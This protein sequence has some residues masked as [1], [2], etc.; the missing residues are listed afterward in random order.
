MCRHVS[1]AACFGAAVGNNGPMRLAFVLRSAVLVAVA[2]LVLVDGPGTSH[3]RDAAA[4]PEATCRVVQLEMT[5][6]P[7]LQ[8][9]A[10]VEDRQGNYVDTAFITRTT[11][12][13]G[14]G[15]R[16]GLMEFDS[17]PL[18]PY[19]RRITTFPVWAQRHGM[20]WPLV[21]F[22]DGVDAQLS[23]P[24][25]QSSRERF[26]CRPIRPDEELWDAVSCATTAYTDKGLLSPDMS[27]PY[28]PRSDITFDPTKDHP[29]VEEMVE[30]NPFDSV[31]HATPL[32]DTLYSASWAVPSEVEAGDYVMWVE[33][34]REF[35]KNEVYD[36][37]SPE[38]DFWSE[39]GEA[40]RGQPSVLYKVDFTLAEDSRTV[41]TTLDYVGYGD[42]DGIDGD[43]RPPDSTITAD[44]PGSGSSRLLV[45]TDG[46]EP[47]RI[48]ISAFGSEDETAPEAPGD[49]DVTAVEA[50][51][52]SARFRAPGDDG[53]EG[54]VS[55]YEV[56]YSASGELDEENFAEGTLLDFQGPVV[57]AGEAQDLVLDELLPRTN[58]SIGI[59]AYDECSNVG[60]LRVFEV[61]TPRPEPGAV[62][63]CFVATAAYG[64]FLA[65]EVTALRS[66]RDMALRTHVPGEL[67]VEGYYTFGPLLAR[68]IAPSETL[69]RAARAALAPAIAELR[70][71][72]F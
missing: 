24:L 44:Q 46:G 33:V 41:A 20:N 58:Y 52:V 66:F 54:T 32:G 11:G 49:V 19:G 40:Y 1:E 8:I 18:W 6:T 35:D 14:L 5:P 60:P 15:N 57:A 29:S 56:R 17:G 16:P 4:Q 13:Y 2:G 47:F 23:H 22:Q 34:S 37:P 48:R 10:W 26:F 71:A 65:N 69:R 12:T 68:A 64:T 39:Y 72:G 43:V 62:D 55:G 28:P 51:Q 7:D 38:L 50:T 59:R 45:T 27:S 3:L 9:V 21:V 25:A 42:P 36:Y 67:A 30:L 53:L 61:T 31:S 63:A 70:A